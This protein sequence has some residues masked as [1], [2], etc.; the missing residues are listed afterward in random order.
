MYNEIDGFIKI[1]GGIRYFV[2]FDGWF[3]RTCDRIKHLI[4]E[5]NGITHNTNPNFFARIRVDSYNSLPIETILTVHNIIIL[6]KSVVS[7]YKIHY[8]NIFLEKGLH[9][10]RSNAEYF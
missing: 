1:Y 3:D 5:K 7:E 2:L 4:S 8:Y 10:D 6:I 9:K